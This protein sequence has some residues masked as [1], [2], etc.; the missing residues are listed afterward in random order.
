MQTEK[1]ESHDLGQK[2]IIIPLHQLPIEWLSISEIG[3]ALPF[4]GSS[5]DLRNFGC[6]GAG[7]KAEPS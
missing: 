7:L 1:G 4:H 2:P 5:N 3:A 6:A